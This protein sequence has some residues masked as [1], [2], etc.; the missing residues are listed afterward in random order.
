MTP[1]DSATPHTAETGPLPAYRTLWLSDLAAT[2]PPPAW[3]WHGYLAPGNTTLL[4]SQWKS[5]KTT[6]VAVLLDKLK[7]GG[8]LAGLAVTPGKAVIISEES[9]A[10]WQQRSHRFA[11]GGHVCWLCRP[12]RTRPTLPQWHGLLDHIL[13][14]HRLHTISLVVVDPL[15]SLFPFRSENHAGHMVEAVQSLHLL[16]AE[17]LVV[18][19][20]HHPSKKPGTDGHHARG[21]GALAAGVDIAI[22]M[23]HC[24]RAS[25]SDRRR[26]LCAYSRFDQ[27]PRRLVIELNPAGTDYLCHGDLQQDEFTQSWHVLRMVLEDARNELTRQEILNDW[28]NDYPAPDKTTLWRWL[29]RAV[30]DGLVCQEGTGRKHDPFRYCLP[31]QQARWQRDPL[32]LLQKL[33]KD[34]LK[35]LRERLD[36]G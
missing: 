13:Q 12:F 8:Q 22:E 19:L 34:D 26:R 21:S 33:E 18:L 23:T 27:T 6:L 1:P 20:L 31:G 9:A 4:T 3:L 7:T 32:Y 14:L 28:P 29:D 16:T 5:G 25:D 35:E 36:M 17:G 30:A 2:P 10:L 15:A 24:Q 11:F